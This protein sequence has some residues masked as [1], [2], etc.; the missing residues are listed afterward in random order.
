MYLI[1]FF[2][3]HFVSDRQIGDTQLAYRGLS[4][5]T[6]NYASCCKSVRPVFIW[7][8]IM[9]RILYRLKSPIWV[10]WCSTTRFIHTQTSAQP[11]TATNQ[12]VLRFHLLYIDKS[13]QTAANKQYSAVDHLIR[14]KVPNTPTP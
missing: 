4:R 11:T 14:A 5:I 9:Q 7:H 8:V 12:L 10:S 13:L 3:Q 1:F 6:Y 2:F